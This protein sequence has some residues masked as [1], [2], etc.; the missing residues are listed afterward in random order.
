MSQLKIREMPQAERPREKLAAR[1]V[2]ALS[3]AELI[4]AAKLLREIHGTFKLAAFLDEA[5]EVYRRRGLYMDR[6]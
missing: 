5:A 1:G 6:F 2:D 3:D 4:A